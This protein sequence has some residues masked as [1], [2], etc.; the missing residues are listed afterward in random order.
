MQNPCAAILIIGNEILSGRTL[1]TNTQTIAKTL[2]KI[3]V[4]IKEARTVPDEKQV[5]IASVLA[6]SQKYDY[7]FTTG[8]IGPTHD[9]ITSLAISEA[10][11]VP[12]VRSEVIYKLLEQFY[13]SRGEHMNKAREK[14]AF[15][16]E[17]STLIR[18]DVT[19]VPGFAI[20]NVYCLAG[21]PDIMESML[22]TIIPSLKHGKVVRSLSHTVMIGESKIAAHFEAL[23]NKYP[24]V[25]MGSY[26]FTREGIHGTS[27][28]L[29]ST[30]Y[31]NLEAAFQD[32]K[33]LIK[34]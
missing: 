10:F 30:D 12:Y 16:P 1:D 2:E 24:G 6:L 22:N 29:R 8:G 7:V 18:N 3:G 20:K 26:P 32:L 11:N 19:K 25:D 34:E 31:I 28:V 21:V 33:S 23:Q 14:M 15:I 13:Q 4:V 27:L 17:G 5:I 9:D